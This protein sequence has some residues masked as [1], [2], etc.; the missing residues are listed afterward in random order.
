[1]LVG[2]QCNGESGNKQSV[3]RWIYAEG[4]IPNGRMEL[5]P[6]E[7]RKTVTR[8]GMENISSVSDM[9]N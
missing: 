4:R 1:M 8:E 9:S 6:T 5:L 3:R 7:M 2:P